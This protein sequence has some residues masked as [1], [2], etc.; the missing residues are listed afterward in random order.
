MTRLGG[1]QS[2]WEG[3]APKPSEPPQRIE[4]VPDKR[5]FE[6]TWPNVV[7]VDHVYTPTLTL[8]LDRVDVL[9]IDASL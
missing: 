2:E 5:R 4:P 3:D 1:W 7:R 6:I 9:E 8:D